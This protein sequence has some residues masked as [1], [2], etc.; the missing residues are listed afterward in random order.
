MKKD[1]LMAMKAKKF[2]RKYVVINLQLINKIFLFIFG[3]G[4]EGNFPHYY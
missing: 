4:N 3:A 1:E 2:E